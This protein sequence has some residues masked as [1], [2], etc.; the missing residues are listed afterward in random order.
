[1]WITNYVIYRQNVFPSL[2]NEFKGDTT[3]YRWTTE[4]KNNV[5][6]SVY[7]ERRRIGTIYNATGCAGVTISQSIWPL[8]PPGAYSQSVDGIYQIPANFKSFLVRTN[9]PQIDVRMNAN[10]VEEQLRGNGFGVALQ[11]AKFSYM[12]G[13]EVTGSILEY[14]SSIN[15][16][17][18][19]RRIRSLVPG[20]L[21]WAKHMIGAPTSVCR[22]GAKDIPEAGATLHNEAGNLGQISGSWDPQQQIEVYG[23]E[24][25]WQSD[26]P[27]KAGRP[28]LSSAR[29]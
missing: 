21:G 2:K 23:C 5:W 20:P 10:G 29:R 13:L 22:I 7:S 25:D 11:N 14:P 8:D 17:I 28:I 27:S 3:G 18:I 15:Q 19:D 4:Y 1:M 6:N 9:V 26:T 12:V 24:A 16:T